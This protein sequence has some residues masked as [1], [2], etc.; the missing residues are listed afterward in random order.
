MRQKNSERLKKAYNEGRKKYTYNPASNWKA[1]KYKQSIEVWFAYDSKYSNQRL[2]KRILDEGLKEWKCSNCQLVEWQN[3]YIEL[4][5]DHID[6][7]NKNNQLNNLRFLC[8]NCH[9]QTSTYCVGG[10]TSADRIKDS[11]IIPLID[12]HNTIVGVLRELN[13]NTGGYN[14]RRVKKLKERQPSK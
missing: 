12:K 6:G 11:D 1:K 4:H 9:S 13:L 8:P 10:R 5:L 7:D 14:Y 3:K 2:K